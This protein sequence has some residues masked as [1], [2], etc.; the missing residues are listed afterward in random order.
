MVEQV[1]KSKQEIAIDIILPTHNFW[2]AKD[3]Q[4]RDIKTTNRGFRLTL[5]CIERLYDNTK[6][7]FHLV[8]VDDSTDNITIK[9]FEEFQKYYNNVTFIHSD[10]PFQCGN[11]FFNIGLSQC[12]HDFVATVMN[13][14][15][16]EPEWEIMALEVFKTDPKVG[17]VGLKCLFPPEQ[18]GKIES[19]GI[20]MWGFQPVDIGRDF[21]GHRMSLVQECPAVQWAFALLRKEAVVGNL[22]EDLYN[23]FKG[24][25]DIDNC[26]AVK[27][28]G[29]KVVYCGL[30]AGYHEPR[31]TRG[32]NSMEAF[33][34]NRE[35]A[36]LFYK[37]W[38]YWDSFIKSGQKDE[39]PPELAPPLAAVLLQ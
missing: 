29:W 32:S 37:R 17:I 5:G 1:V 34:K 7:P 33:Q 38:G 13:S 6:T 25:D 2:L 3:E 22:D 19:A 39:L 12:Q 4:K 8:V 11:Q 21:P 36:H 20:T 23:G 10:V 35:N 30:G 15:K 27:A 14:T 16:V 18:G 9:Y 24:W 26:F 31:A 28:K